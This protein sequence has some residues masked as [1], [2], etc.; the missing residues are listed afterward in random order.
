MGGEERAAL[1]LRL[2]GYRILERNYRVASGEIDLIARRGAVL[3]F[4]EVKTRRTR[5]KGR[6]IEAVHDR[7]VRRLSNAAAAYVQAERPKGVRTF[8]FDVIGVGPER[9]LLGMPRVEHLENAFEAPP[10]FSV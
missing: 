2:R 1:H 7:K 8:R 5:G 4:V 9:N 10:I 6:P 3:A